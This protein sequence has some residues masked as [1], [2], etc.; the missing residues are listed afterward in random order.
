[1]A[2]QRTA[3]LVSRGLGHSQTPALLTRH[4]KRSCAE[5][6]KSYA[7]KRQSTPVSSHAVTNKPAAAH[8]DRR[9]GTHQ[10]TAHVLRCFPLHRSL[11]RSYVRVLARLNYGSDIRRLH[12]MGCSHGD[13]YP[14]LARRLHV[15]PS[16]V[17]QRVSRTPWQKIP[18]EQPQ[19]K[20]MIAL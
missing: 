11:A 14:K 3:C 2:A 1:M 5:W 13:V 20:C 19:C 15:S 18:W 8:T 9:I 17:R 6:I 16:P 7:V 12:Q 10:H 4:A